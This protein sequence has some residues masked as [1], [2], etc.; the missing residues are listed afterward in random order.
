MFY[1]ESHACR[2]FRPLWDVLHQGRV[3]SERVLGPQAILGVLVPKFSIEYYMHVVHGFMQSSAYM[4]TCF[5]S[6]DK[7]CLV[8]KNGTW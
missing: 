6:V 4:H 8:A 2:G 3:S 5:G 7:A 1:L